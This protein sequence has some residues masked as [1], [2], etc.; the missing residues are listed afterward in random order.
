[1]GSGFKLHLIQILKLC[2]DK[3]RTPLLRMN[4]R[5]ADLPISRSQHEILRLSSPQSKLISWQTIARI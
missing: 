5:P 4:G 3:L 2:N 1:M